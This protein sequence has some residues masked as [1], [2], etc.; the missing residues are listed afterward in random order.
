MC[1]YFL[2]WTEQIFTKFNVKCNEHALFEFIYI[3]ISIY[4]GL[5]DKIVPNNSSFV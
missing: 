2:Y 5:K 3:A 1:Y 4:W